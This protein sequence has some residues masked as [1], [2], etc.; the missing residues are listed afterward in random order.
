MPSPS[1]ASTPS[2]SPSWAIALAALVATTAETPKIAPVETSKMPA[3]MQIVT[4]QA[5]IPSG[6][7]WSRMFSRLRWVRNVS[8]AKLS[9][10]EQ[11]EEREHD[12][13]V[14][15]LERRRAARA[16]A[17]GRRGRRPL[18]L[19][20]ASSARAGWRTPRA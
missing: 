11:R 15:D 5:M 3:M 18:R 19:M 20:L 17:A 4:A 6:A 12:P 13:E 16:C 7:D 10:D 9:A 8:V 1:P 2:T 14:A